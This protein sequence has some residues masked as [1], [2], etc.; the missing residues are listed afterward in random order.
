MGNVDLIIGWEKYETVFMGKE[1]S[2]EIRP[3]KRW[4]W[5]VIAPLFQDMPDKKKGETNQQFAARLTKD[6]RGKLTAQSEKIH[7]KS[8][9]IFKDHVR[10]IQGITVNQKP[11]TFDIMSEEIHFMN[12]CIQICGKL[13]EISQLT[14]GE[15]KNS[16]GQPD[17][18]TSE[19][20]TEAE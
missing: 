12:L 5:F 16:A 6:E 3:L 17:S 1:I 15:E 18:Q 9:D 8:K 7:E 2:M 11:I 19:Q 14:E 4:A 13:M 20:Q 10:N